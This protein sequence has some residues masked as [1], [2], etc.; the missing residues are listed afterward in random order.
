MLHK[1]FKFK[2]NSFFYTLYTVILGNSWNRYVYSTWI[3]S[4]LEK[5]RYRS[6]KSNP[7]LL[8]RMNFDEHIPWKRH[9]GSYLPCTLLLLYDI[10]TPWGVTI[11]ISNFQLCK[12]TQSL[13]TPDN[14]IGCYLDIPGGNVNFLSRDSSWTIDD[15]NKI[16]TNLYIS[17]NYRDGK[18]V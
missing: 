5:Y 11:I 15:I 17:N 16:K 9:W 7:L 18:I 2:S 1:I 14:N 13:S 6:P 4:L 12:N 10:A 8:T 3:Y